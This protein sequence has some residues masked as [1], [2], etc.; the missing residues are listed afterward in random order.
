L[1][2][3]F[4]ENRFNLV[5]SESVFA[6]QIGR[7][8]LGFAG[9][10][11][12][13]LVFLV[14]GQG[15]AAEPVPVHAVAGQGV[16]RID[17]DGP[18]RVRGVVTGVFPGEDGLEGFFIQEAE[19][20]PDGLPSGLFVYAPELGAEA[21]R[22]LEPGRV[23]R[24]VGW[25]DQYRGRPQ[26]EGL[27][28]LELLG[29][30]EMSA[31]PLRLPPED[32]ER[33][34]GVLV[35]TQQPLT[36]T[37]NSDLALY[38]SLELAAGGRAFQD[39]NF[40]PGQGPA[41]PDREGLR[42]VLDDGRYSRDPDP[43]PYLS[44][45]GTRRVGSRVEKGLTGIFSR[46]FHQSRIHP[47]QSTEFHRT[48]PRPEP[49]PD[50]DRK[51]IRAAVLNTDSYFLSLGERGADN[52]SELRRQ[53]TKLLTA[54]ERLS[55][56]VLVLLEL[57]NR[58]EVAR[59]FR[60]RLARSSGHPWRLV[61]TDDSPSGVIRIAMVYRSDRVEQLGA[62][63]RDWRGI[64]DRPPLVAAFRPRNGGEPFAVAGI[65]FK[66]KGDCPAGAEK[67]GGCWNRRRVRQ[68]RA[69]LGFLRR[70]RRGHDD[71]PV[72]VA[73]DLNAY[74]A[75]EPV[76][77]LEGAGWTD[78]IASR[79]P[80]RERSTYVYD[81]ESGYLDHLLAGPG[82]A[83]RVEAVRIHAIN[84]DEP[85]FLEYDRGGPGGRHASDSPFRCSDHDPVTADISTR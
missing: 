47:T 10:F 12:L 18:V 77:V 16:E 66:S 84:A 76:R 53:R 62:A 44:D 7:K 81:G 29:R 23:V 75:E 6:F 33:L 30:K 28:R 21:I 56:D 83:K 68:A 26:L 27:K 8:V 42:I 48:N 40:A 3:E 19:P 37:G 17:P 34:E 11:G 64:H 20:A 9:L 50:P 13:I 24:L 67:E 38:G 43:V 36:V 55:A 5:R 79:L 72:L 22:A 45:A 52:Q 74:G 31:Y 57:E 85:A 63:A 49:L 71:M 73:G 82:L 41:N 25:P 70:W 35:R 14:A 46:A 4:C 15:V 58:D 39:R 59:D 60:R 61:Q 54:A 51:S 78:L 69:L 65:H 32:P 1:A 2:V 80:W